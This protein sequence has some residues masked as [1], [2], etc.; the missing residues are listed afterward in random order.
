MLVLYINIPEKVDILNIVNNTE[1]LFV[2]VVSWAEGRLPWPS[3][4]Q[5]KR[6]HFY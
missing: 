6:K 3:H 2:G 4:E 5:I 1:Y